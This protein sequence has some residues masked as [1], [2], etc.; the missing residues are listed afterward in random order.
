[1]SRSQANT[2]I[3]NTLGVIAVIG[4]LFATLGAWLYD[5]LRNFH[6]GDDGLRHAEIVEVLPYFFW[7]AVWFG[8]LLGR[9]GA[10]RLV[11]NVRCL[12][13]MAAG[14]ILGRAAFFMVAGDLTTPSNRLEGVAFASISAAAH[15][16]A[17][18][19]ALMGAAAGA[20]LAWTLPARRLPGW[21]YRRGQTELL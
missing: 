15:V 10:A 18:L 21:S 9:R 6:W 1:M 20:A 8:L 11:C 19:C 3:S 4:M 12:C 2:T 5:G 14:A 7:F 16:I 13:W 17:W